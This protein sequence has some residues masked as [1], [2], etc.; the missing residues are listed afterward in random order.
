MPE[1]TD[2]TTISIPIMD[3]LQDAIDTIEELKQDPIAAPTEST[4]ME[5]AKVLQFSNTL[6]TYSNYFNEIDKAMSVI[7]EADKVFADYAAKF[8]NDQYRI[9]MQKAF[10]TF[11]VTIELATKKREYR[12]LVR[13]KRATLEAIRS[14]L[15]V[16]KLKADEAINTRPVGGPVPARTGTGTNTTPVNI[17]IKPFRNDKSQSFR[18]FWNIFTA[19]YDSN[20][21]MT[22]VQKLIALISLL[23]G[24]PQKLIECIDI[25]ESNYKIVVDDL[26]R[27][28]YNES[29]IISELY[30]QLVNLKACNS[31][32][33]EY[34]FSMSL[35]NICKQLTDLGKG[36]E[37]TEMWRTF[38]AKLTKSTIREIE[39]RRLQVT[40]WNTKMFLSELREITTQEQAIHQLYISE[41]RKK[42]THINNF[43]NRNVKVSNVVVQNNSEDE[44]DKDDER[45]DTTT[46]LSTIIETSTEDTQKRN[47]SSICKQENRPTDDSNRSVIYWKCSFCKGMHYNSQCNVYKTAEARKKQAFNNRLCFRC[48]TS[49]HITGQCTAKFVCKHCSQ[50]HHSLVCSD[51]RPE[52]SSTAINKLRSSYSSTVEAKVEQI[53]QT[54]PITINSL[55]SGVTSVSTMPIL[56]SI[57]MPV[58]NPANSKTRTSAIVLL[59]PGS[60]TTFVKKSLV[61]KLH[62]EEKSCKNLRLSGIN[63][64]ERTDIESSEVEIGLH[65][66]QGFVKILKAFTLNQIVQP[67]LAIN[68][69]KED[70]QSLNKKCLRL[71]NKTIEP[72]ILIGIDYY[73]DLDVRTVKKLSNGFWLTESKLGRMI[74]GN[75]KVRTLN[76]TADA[77]SYPTIA[78]I[79]QKSIAKL[80]DEKKFE[81]PTV[82]KRTHNVLPKDDHKKLD[83]K[84]V[85]KHFSVGSVAITSIAKDPGGL[86][87]PGSFHP[88]SGVK[89]RDVKP[90]VKL[91]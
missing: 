74:S 22:N 65:S 68:F 64:L 85:D 32:I 80:N 15:A 51:W 87:R 88:R 59:D 13:N 63:A 21:E 84:L 70:E 27:R 82:K 8:S 11:K 44:S 53:E 77:Q 73:H 75:G 20:N 4:A 16:E 30:Y 48:L 81:P 83:K 60:Q 86:N 31:A 38:E 50:A 43:P 46:S 47:L 57:K 52:M 61:K 33:D 90:G 40:T 6:I 72:D 71:D 5:S 2:S 37:T 12:N 78:L 35:D 23:E 58:F 9:A 79:N 7:T 18:T 76:Q 28:Y 89:V 91:T 66:E 14:G 3:Q 25:T 49:G 34:E 56:M 42:E 62:I 54:K 39:K 19:L 10:N 26:K 29:A 67:H 17:A 41:H 24:E 55:I 1:P 36:I 69:A 45:I